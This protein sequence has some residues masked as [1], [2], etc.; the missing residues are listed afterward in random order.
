MNEGVRVAR[1]GT[2]SVKVERE[3]GRERERREKVTL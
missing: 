1:V 3:R 2:K